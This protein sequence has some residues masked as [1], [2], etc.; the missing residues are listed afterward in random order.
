[1]LNIINTEFLKLKRS[2]MLILLLLGSL[3]TPSMMIVDAIKIHYSNPNGIITLSALFDSN[4]MY[5]MLLFGLIVCVLVGTYLFTREYKENTIKNIIPIPVSKISFI[6]SKLIMLLILVMSFMLI[7]WTYTVIFST[8]FN[9][10][11]GLN[12]FSII[13]MIEYLVQMILGGILLFLTIT[14]F[15]FIGI[16]TKGIIVP[17]IAATTV[18]MGNAGLTNESIGA[19]FPWTASFLLINGRLSETGYSELLVISIIGFISIFGFI[20]SILYF[21]KEDID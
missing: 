19:L 6:I 9:I 13:V 3:V 7:S 5:S 21:Q 16:W 15:F 18:A 20:A 17:T 12:N 11:Y 2:K 8:L 10:M 4:L 1:M 14:P